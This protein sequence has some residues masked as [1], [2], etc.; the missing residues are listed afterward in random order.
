MDRP[1][2]VVV[3]AGLAGAASA[4]HL[5]RAGAR[6]TVVETEADAGRHASGRNAGILRTAMPD[7][8]L[9][10]LAAESRGFYLDPP[11]GFADGPLVRGRGV[12]LAAGPAHA[13]SLRGWARNPACASGLEE[14][15]PAELRKRVPELAGDLA[16][17][18]LQPQEG[19]FDVHRVLH[20][21]LRGAAAAGARIRLAA[22]ATALLLRNGA[23]TGVRLADEVL[24]ADAV[25]LA[26]G[27][28]A[29]DLPA[30]CGL[31][32]A[33]RPYR[34]HLLCTGPLPEVDPA[35]PV[36]WLLGEEFYFRPESGGLL[37]CACDHQPVAAERGEQSTGT[38]AEDLAVRVE[39]WLPAFAE[40]PA[41]RIWAGTRTFAPDGRFVLGSDPRLT[42]LFWAAGLGGHGVT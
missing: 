18:F 38:A 19:E 6:V 13:D 9:H 12:W 11:A 41:A 16:A 26:G 8:V 15:N 1:R 30:A 37:L 20:G 35:G 22:P 14:R 2:I 29:R 4:W 3:G 7:P 33:V 39:R 36:V 40:A 10:G 25:L 42:G 32:L 23:C 17:A 28:W 5:A 31:P 34:R 24:E 27:A 21:F